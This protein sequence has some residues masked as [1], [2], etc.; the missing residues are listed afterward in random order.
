MGNVYFELTE[1]FNREGTIAL[2]SSGQAVVW[3]R[4]ALMSKDGDWVVE[5]SAA[6]CQRILTML[7]SRGARYRP[8]APLDPRWLAGGW[9]SHLEYQDGRKRRIRCDFVSRPP[10]VDPGT[11]RAL[12][13]RPPAPG[14]LAVIDLESLILLKRTQRAKDYP[15]IGELARSLPEALELRYTTDPDRILALAARW[16]EGID[17]VPV[18]EACR[19]ASRDAVVVALARE[20]DALQQADRVRVEAYA[21]A[22][23]EYVDALRRSGLLERPCAESHPALVE[24]A[25]RLLPPVLQAGGGDGCNC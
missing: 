8:G 11:V 23:R 24:I 2:L 4:K 13:R 10:R 12:L 6:A 14:A 5:E 7:S 15:V 25:A 21:E 9:S 20:N 1:E 22:S 18:R 17:R 3:Y 16:G 19:G